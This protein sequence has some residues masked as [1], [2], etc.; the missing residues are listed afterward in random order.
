MLFGLPST[1]TDPSAGSG[2]VAVG[3]PARPSR[4][5]LQSTPRLTAG[6]VSTAWGRPMQAL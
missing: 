2:L 3:T 1:L 6:E 4:G 5:E